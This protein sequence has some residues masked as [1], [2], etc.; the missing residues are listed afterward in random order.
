MKTI[1]RITILAAYTTVVAAT[2]SI[3]TLLVRDLRWLWPPALA[4]IVGLDH[5]PTA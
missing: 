3:L 4:G 5:R 2:A 1:R